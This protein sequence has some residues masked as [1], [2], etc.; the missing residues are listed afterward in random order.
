MTL[1]NKEYK[2][3]DLI[4]VGL[5]HPVDESVC[6]QCHNENVPIPD[7]VFNYEEMKGKGLHEHFPLKYNHD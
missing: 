7:Y 3:A 2:R 1:Q 4:A 5:V 6:V